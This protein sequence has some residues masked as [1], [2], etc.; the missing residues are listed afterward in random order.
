V[1][2]LLCRRGAVL[3]GTTLVT[4]LTA[5]SPA[6]AFP[7]RPA[8]PAALWASTNGTGISLG[9]EQPRAGSPA[10]SFRVYENDQ[11]VARTG[12]TA[13]HLEV[14]FG[15]SHTYTVTAVDHRGRE[16][17][18]TTP[19]TGR[20][21]LSGVDPECTPEAGTPITVTEVTASAVALRWE[22]HPLGGAL[23]LWIDGR[24]LGTTSL[25]S[26][27]IGGLAPGTVHHVELYRY[28]QCHTGD[29]Y[30]AVASAGIT[31]APGGAARPGS[32]AG[33]VVTG[34]TDSTVGLSWT[35]PAGPAPAR[36]AV[37]DGA[38][39]VGVTTGTTTTVDRLHPATG[40]R[41]TV[42]ALDAA[43][44]E[45]AHSAAVTAATETCASR[46]PRP[47]ALR[48]TPTSSSSIRLSWA[49][50]A[51][52]DTYTVLDGDVPVADTRYSQIVLTGLPPASHHTY[53][54]VANLAQDCGTSPPGRHVEV[55][56]LDGPAARP[57]PPGSLAVMDNVAG[58]WPVPARLTLTWSP[59]RGGAPATGYRV[60]EGAEVAGETAGTSLTLPVGAAT[61]H[62]YVVVA[63]DPAGHESAPS[64]RVT[65][66]ATYLPP[67]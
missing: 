54:V 5:V 44:A 12:T 39:L 50:E 65:V 42:A 59:A 31:T 57:A 47:V 6:S 28:R 49:F 14:P 36:Y 48:A 43:G 21:W 19:A 2:P 13:A 18:R 7:A 37:Y 38:V 61:T 56:A 27:R 67:P 25:T 41:F 10:S 20:S 3:A 1:S 32:P 46:P 34:R 60:Y 4:L 26:A 8:T 17:A 52:A 45:S 33:L 64:A 58:V 24:S 51:A 35:A 11:V 30:V 40:H 22:R 53:R 15:S 9:W 66:R 29:E 16:S 55:A 23:D 63:V 62:E